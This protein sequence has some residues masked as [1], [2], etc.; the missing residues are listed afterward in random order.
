[1]FLTFSQSVSLK[2]IDVE[3]NKKLKKFWA[4]QMSVVA[5]LK[6]ILG[7]LLKPGSQQC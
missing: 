4:E 7:K 3:E 1:M 6:E 2:E 5:L